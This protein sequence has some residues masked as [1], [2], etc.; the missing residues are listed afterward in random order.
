MA[1][2]IRVMENS[3]RFLR[4]ALA[5]RRYGPAD[6]QQSIG[7]TSVERAVSN[8]FKPN[9][10]ESLFAMTRLLPAADRLG[11]PNKADA[12]GWSLTA[13]HDVS[14][15]FRLQPYGYQRGPHDTPVKPGHI[16]FEVYQRLFSRSIVVA[17][18]CLQYSPDN[19]AN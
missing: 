16:S 11:R 14:G 8:R 9:K 12:A 6:S 3:V 17:L 18:T 1:I 15:H 13:R 2:Y 19:D 7:Q 10:G 5:Y 4:L